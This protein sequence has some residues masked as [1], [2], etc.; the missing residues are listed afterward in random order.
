MARSGE[1]LTVESDP[2]P[3]A[4][5]DPI[6]AVRTSMHAGPGCYVATEEDRAAYAT[7]L[8]EA[9]SDEATMTLEVFSWK[10][11]VDVSMARLTARARPA[12]AGV[13]RGRRRVRSHSTDRS[14]RS[15]SERQAQRARAEDR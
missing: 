11:Y 3:P 8:A 9:G 13:R 4:D 1:D 14:E 12:S 6:E 10:R 15:R 2:E 5:S 7:Y